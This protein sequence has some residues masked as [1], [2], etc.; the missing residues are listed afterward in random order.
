MDLAFESWRSSDSSGFKGSKIE[1]LVFR[2]SAIKMMKF[3]LLFLINLSNAQQPGTKV[4]GNPTI[5]VTECTVA[6]GC[7]SKEH[8]LVLDAN[9]RWIHN[10]QFQNC[11][12]GNEWDTSICSDPDSCAEKCVVEGVDAAQYKN[13]YGV[14]PVPGRKKRKGC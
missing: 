4:E 8:K 10:G 5:A 9:W 2:T 6:K 13:T 1:S 11:Y 14:T 3:I 12:T 7:N